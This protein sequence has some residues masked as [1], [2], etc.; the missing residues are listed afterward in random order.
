MNKTIELYLSIILTVVFAILIPVHITKTYVEI[1]ERNAE[2]YDAAFVA[3]ELETTR[4]ADLRDFKEEYSLLAY[5]KYQSAVNLIYQNGKVIIPDGT[6]YLKIRYGSDVR[7][8]I[9]E[10]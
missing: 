6:K 5:N 9:Y 1:S 10:E 3:W 4:E 7:W 2:K 8:I